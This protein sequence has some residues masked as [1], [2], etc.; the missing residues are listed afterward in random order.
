MADNGDIQTDGT[1]ELSQLST[2]GK[3]SAWPGN[4]QMK[5]P[6]SKVSLNKPSTINA[7]PA[8]SEGMTT[9]DVVAHYK[10]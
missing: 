1:W 9:T 7:P 5:K 6:V 10:N 2:T 3:G 8:K 4:Q